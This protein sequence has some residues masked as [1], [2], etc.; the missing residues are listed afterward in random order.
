MTALYL[1]AVLDTEDLCL[2][3]RVL[4]MDVSAFQRSAPSRQTSLASR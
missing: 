1:A 4:S 3:A 2:A